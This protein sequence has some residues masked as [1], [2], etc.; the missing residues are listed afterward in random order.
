MVVQVTIDAMG[1]GGA[2]PCPWLEGG[3][4]LKAECTVSVWSTH[5]FDFR[6]KWSKLLV[7]GRRAKYSES[8]RRE[9]DHCPSA[10]KCCFCPFVPFG[11][12][13]LPMKNK[14]KETH[15][16]VTSCSAPQATGSYLA[17]PS[18]HHTGGGGFRG[19]QTSHRNGANFWV[20]PRN[21]PHK[22]QGLQRTSCCEICHIEID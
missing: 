8:C 1:E 15:S 19:H 18:H 5:C 13:P 11:V 10:H 14:Q 3:G 9:W 20:C 12:P 4:A 7:H 2:K 21:L 6:R 22:T 17:I 16:Q